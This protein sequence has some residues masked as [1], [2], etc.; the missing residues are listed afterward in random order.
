MLLNVVCPLMLLYTYY[1]LAIQNWA[2]SG[3]NQT[4][5]LI[6]GLWPQNENGE[7]PSWCNGT[8]YYPVSGSLEQEMQTYWNAGDDNQNFWGHEWNKHGTCTQAQAGLDEGAY[9]QQAITLFRDFEGPS[10]P[11]GEDTCIHSCYDLDFNPRTCGPQN[12]D[13]PDWG[14]RKTHIFRDDRSVI[15]AL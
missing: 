11:A 8:A 12:R 1:E 7:Y 6:H 15:R 3:T 9:F 5:Y 14:P 2:S 4:T 13:I 10:C